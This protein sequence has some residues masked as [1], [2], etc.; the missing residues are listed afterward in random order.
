M[1]RLGKRT[2]PPIASD[3]E[4]RALLERYRCPVPFHAV[5]ARFLGNIALPDMQAS[6]IKMVEALWGGELPTLGTIDAANELIG[7]L[8]MGLWNRLTR[9]QE[10]SA[11]FRL[12]YRDNLDGTRIASFVDVPGGIALC[13]NKLL[14]LPHQTLPLPHEALPLPHPPASAG[15]LQSHQT[16]SRGLCPAASP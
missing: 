15:F 10:R 8:G 1:I 3:N 13:L 2:T 16:P 9:H 11:P 7:A 12:V 6:P 4:V 5:R 14:P